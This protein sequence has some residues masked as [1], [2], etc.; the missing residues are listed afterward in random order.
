MANY[1]GT[2]HIGVDVDL[3]A[4]QMIA[5]LYSGCMIT[6]FPVGPFPILPLIE[7]LPSPGRNQLN[8]FWDDISTAIVSDKKYG[9]VM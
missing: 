3:T 4:C 9:C 7:L 1:T 5:A 8:R 6:V 2:Y